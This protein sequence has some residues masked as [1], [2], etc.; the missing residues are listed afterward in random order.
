M[1]LIDLSVPTTASMPVH[2]GD[3]R[4]ELKQIGNI[5]TDGF[6]GHMLCINTHAGTHIDAPRH[7]IQNGKGLDHF[8]LEKFTGRGVVIKIENQQFDLSVIKTFDIQKDTIV[9]FNTGMSE[10]FD[11]PEYFEKYPA[12][13]KEVAKYLVAKEIKLVGVD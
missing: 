1:K 6:E 8:P 2:P 4:T 10:S 12:I 11:K 7:M 3:P 9:L 13:P 5:P